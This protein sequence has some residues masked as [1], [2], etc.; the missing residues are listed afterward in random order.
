VV[1]V[2]KILGKKNIRLDDPAA[3]IDTRILETLIDIDG[4]D[5][6]PVGLRMDV[7]ILTGPEADKTLPPY[8]P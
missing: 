3:K 4:H 2:A 6:L 8:R 7:F 5:L 1:R